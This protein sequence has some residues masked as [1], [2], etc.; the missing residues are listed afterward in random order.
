MTARDEVC[1]LLGRA[2]RIAVLTGAGMSAESGVPTFR[3]ALT[4]LWSRFDPAQL[5]TPEAFRANPQ[6]VWRWYAERRAGVLRA[7]PHA[8]HRVLA[9]AA[10]RFERF[11]LITQNVD[12]L[13]ARAG[14]RDVLELHGN[15]LASH[16]F[17]ECGTRFARSEELP[18]GEPPRCPNCC[19]PLRPSVV[20]FGEALD[21]ATLMRAERE[22]AAAE[23]VLVVGTS[24][25]VHPAARLPWIGRE[26]GATVVI[27]NPH[28]SELD[29]VA[30]VR[31]AESAAQALPAV[32]GAA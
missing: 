32:L 27:V 24:G 9:Q 29:A 17:D 26:A 21:P 1:A 19:A 10:G 31:L 4:G 8:G 16:C 25:L 22:V 13:H 3:D 2:R 23:V 20:W 15:I 14:S 7:E 11:A 6:L 18:D 5:A 12:G 30:H 28:P